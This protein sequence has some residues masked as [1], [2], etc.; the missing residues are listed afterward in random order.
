MRA[1]T[2]ASVCSVY[3]TE[4]L[5]MMLNRTELVGGGL[6][7]GALGRPDIQR[8]PRQVNKHILSHIRGFIHD[9]YFATWFLTPSEV[10]HPRVDSLQAAIVREPPLNGPAR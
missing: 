4:V 2:V 9:T 1:G 8:S 6:C 7:C 5:T 10:M 3:G